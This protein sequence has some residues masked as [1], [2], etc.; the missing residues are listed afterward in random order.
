ML[1]IKSCKLKLYRLY[2]PAMNMVVV[3]NPTPQSLG[4]PAEL[5]SDVNAVVSRRESELEFSFHFKPPGLLEISNCLESDIEGK[6]KKKKK[7]KKGQVLLLPRIL[8][9]KNMKSHSGYGRIHNK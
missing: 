2:V 6:E 1:A 4:G 8:I 3:A 5:E 9:C 7:K